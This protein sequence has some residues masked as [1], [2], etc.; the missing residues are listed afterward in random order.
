MRGILQNEHKARE[1][2][3][4]LI[5]SLRTIQWHGNPLDV[6]LG[7]SDEERDGEMKGNRG[8][9]NEMGGRQRERVG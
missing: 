4:N 5:I 3:E 2:K 9:K 6:F 7:G 8:T 1:V